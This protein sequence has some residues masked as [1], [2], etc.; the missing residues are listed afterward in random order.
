[1]PDSA[2]S[3]QPQAARDAPRARSAVPCRPSPGRSR[4]GRCVRARSPGE[5][6]RSAVRAGG[7]VLEQ[8]GTCSGVAG[9]AV[10]VGVYFV[11]ALVFTPSWIPE[12]VEE[13]DPRPGCDRRRRRPRAA[14]P[15]PPPRPA[16]MQAL[17]RA[18]GRPRNRTP[19]AV[20]PVP[21][22]AFDAAPRPSARHRR[23]PVLAEQ[24]NAK[25]VTATL[26]GA[27]G[28]GRDRHPR[29][30]RRVFGRRDRETDYARRLL[31]L[32]DDTMLVLCD[33]VSTRRFPHR[34]RRHAPS[35]WSAHRHPP[36]AGARDSTRLLRVAIGVLTVRS[37]PPITV[38]C[39]DAPAT[40]RATGWPPPC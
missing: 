1:M 13:A 34:T 28:V 9:A 20:R 33:R 27:D 40:P 16:P 30:A 19:G 25:H 2:M 29:P 37:S 5:L 3:V 12:R 39:A 8:T 32:L 23:E 14:Q 4:C 6:T 7:C 26:R 15:A 35:S 24:P 21:D 18:A 22:G 36:L 38:T 10:A 31:H 11:L 17:F